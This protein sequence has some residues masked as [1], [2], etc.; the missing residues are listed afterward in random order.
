MKIRLAFGRK[1][2]ALSQQTKRFLTTYANSQ[3]S[4]LIF[5][6]QSVSFIYK[7]WIIMKDGNW[8]HYIF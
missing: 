7:F 1:R 5:F 8:V 2:Q 3:P 6:K 4:A